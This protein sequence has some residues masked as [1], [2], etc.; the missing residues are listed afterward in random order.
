[1]FKKLN[2]L[3]KLLKLFLEEPTREFNVRE[4]ARLLRISPAT[5]SK[6]LKL[7]VKEG[8]LK[9]RR[10]RMLKLYRANLESDFYR[11]IKVFY[12]IRKIKDSGLIEEL[13]NFYLK[14]T[15]ILFGSCADGMDTET[16][17]IDLLII[18]EKTEEFPNIKKFERKLKRR[19]QLFVIKEIKD[20]K[21]EH[22][23]NN[24]LN[25]IVIQGR[26]RWM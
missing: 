19:I 1:M 6:E 17:D 13:N 12:N 20:L 24:I 2:K 22:F 26:V 8:L 18:S 5:A 11:D 15:I 10:E 23:I 14:P 7:L 25:G 9:E 16:S 4:V 21:N 3:I